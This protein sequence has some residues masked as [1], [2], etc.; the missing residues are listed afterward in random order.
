MSSI[1]VD[2]LTGKTTAGSVTVT[3]EQGGATMQLQ[4]GLAKAWGNANVN[5]STPAFRDSF[6]FDSILDEGT[7]LYE[8]QFTNPMNNGDYSATMTCSAKGSENAFANIMTTGDEADTYRKHSST[9]IGCTSW[10]EN[11][12]A[13]GDP[14]HLQSAVHGDLA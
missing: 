13:N 7:G 6:N 9:I 1:L 5:Q 3:S 4:Q 12:G 8:F 2:N 14:N 10:N 11:G